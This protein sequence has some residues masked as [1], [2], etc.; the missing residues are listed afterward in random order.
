MH[1][2]QAKLNVKAHKI[3][4]ENQYNKVDVTRLTC[5]SN[6]LFHQMGYLTILF[7]NIKFKCS[8]SYI[9]EQC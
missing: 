7:T 5:I 6:P 2:K 3:Y 1:V 4:N 9:T 8:H